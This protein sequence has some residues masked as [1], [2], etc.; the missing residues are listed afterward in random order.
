M[1]AIE[2]IKESIKTHI[3]WAEY[4]E[5]NHAMENH[6]EYKKLGNA[7]FHRE[8]IKRYTEAIV[9][10]KQL[11]EDNKRLLDAYDTVKWPAIERVM[12]DLRKENERLQSLKGGTE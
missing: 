9:E 11:Q 2:I 7:L 8:C 12:L 3:D 4:F 1:K 10:I 5:E 6:P